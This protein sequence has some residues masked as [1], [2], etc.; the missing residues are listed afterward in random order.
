MWDKDEVKKSQKSCLMRWTT[1]KR[2]LRLF[3]QLGRAEGSVQLAVS[4]A[5][6]WLKPAAFLS[7]A[8]ENEMLKIIKRY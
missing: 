5:C 3:R 1:T 6:D 7:T 8:N 2:V 4:C